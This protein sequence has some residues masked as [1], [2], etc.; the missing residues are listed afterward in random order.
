MEGGWKV[1]FTQGGLR[2]LTLSIDKIHTPGHI[3]Y[4]PIKEEQQQIK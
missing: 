3:G 2:L 4:M 1:V